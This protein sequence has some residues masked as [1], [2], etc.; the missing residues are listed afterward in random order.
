MDRIRTEADIA[1]ALDRL[2]A[3]D[4]LLAAARAGVEDV[5]LRLFDADFA[6]MCRIVAGQ[7]LST[8]SAAAVYA[9]VCRAFDPLTAEAILTADDGVLRA[10]GL[11]RQKAATFRAVAG[12][13]AGGL[14]LAALAELPAEEARTSL[15]A[16]R[17]IG[18]WSADLYLMFCAGHPD[19]FPVGDLAVRRGAQ[20]ALGLGEEPAPDALDA[21]AARWSPD[22]STAARLMWAVYRLDRPATTVG[23]TAV[24][25][26]APL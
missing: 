17:G 2:G 15:E 10:A 25:E 12:A 24:P 23:Q 20:R 5:P 16:I 18:R 13:V 9:K 19:V 1:A 14:D 21:I 26:G 8:Q 3:A 7:Q 11:S 22:R 6:G 4:P